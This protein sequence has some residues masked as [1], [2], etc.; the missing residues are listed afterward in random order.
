[1]EWLDNINDRKFVTLRLYD[2]SEGNAPCLEFN[3]LKLSDEPDW[4][5]MPEEWHCCS[6]RCTFTLRTTSGC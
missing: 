4:N 5:P 1:M 2:L 6:E 3:P